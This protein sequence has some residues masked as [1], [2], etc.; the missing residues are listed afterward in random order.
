MRIALNLYVE[1]HVAGEIWRIEIGI[2]VSRGITRGTGRIKYDRLNRVGLIGTN[3]AD[4][5]EGHN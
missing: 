5:S 2:N 3:N 4:G 1:G